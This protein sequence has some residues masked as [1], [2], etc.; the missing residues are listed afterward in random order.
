MK[1]F[2]EKGY[3]Y[4]I[5]SVGINDTYKK[6]STTYYK[7]SLKG[8]LNLMILNNISPIFLD[9]PDYDIQKAYNCQKI[10]KKLL[11]RLSM[12]INGITID[13]KQEYRDILKETVCERADILNY[14]EW[15]KHYSKDLKDYY[16]EDGIHL[17]KAGYAKL[18]SCIAAHIQLSFNEK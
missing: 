12:L 8:L 16:L 3:D 14:Q 11:R 13:C 18:D 5:I 10:S 7:E 1:N 2:I 17:N 9:I 15:N 6:M 4:C